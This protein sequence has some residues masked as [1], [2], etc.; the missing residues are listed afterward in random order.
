[1]PC[2]SILFRSASCFSFWR[3]KLIRNASCSACCFASIE[4]FSMVGSCT[5]RSSTFSM[6]T[7]RG[8]SCAISSSRIC[9]CTS[10]RSYRRAQRR[11]H[12]FFGIVCA[13]LLVDLGRLRMVQV[14]QQRGV[15][16]QNQPL[17]RGHAGAL[18][19]RL[20]LDRKSLHGLQRVDQVDSLS[21]RFSRHLPEQGQHAYVPR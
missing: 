19:H 10:R 1:M 4:L 7:P 17:I 18:F 13:D 2:A 20:R 9:C 12:N 16:R 14:K 5:S 21:E 6:I 3:M 15:E 11:L 8:A